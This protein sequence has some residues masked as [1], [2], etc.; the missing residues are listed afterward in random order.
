MDEQYEQANI[1]LTRA[2]IEN[3]GAVTGRLLSRVLSCDIPCAKLLIARFYANQ[4]PPRKV[5]AEFMLIGPKAEPQP[6]LDEPESDFELDS[7]T[8]TPASKPDSEPQPQP[9]ELESES[10]SSSPK[11][12]IIPFS[13]GGFPYDKRPPSPEPVTTT[14]RQL[15]SETSL[16]AAKQE[17]ACVTSQE[18]YAVAHN[19]LNASERLHLLCRANRLRPPPHLLVTEAPFPTIE[20][21]PTIIQQ[22]NSNAFKPSNHPDSDAVLNQTTPISQNPSISQNTLPDQDAHPDIKHK[23]NKKGSAGFAALINKRKSGKSTASPTPAPAPQTQSTV[24][25]ALFTA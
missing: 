3:K 19:S 10:R 5:H 14:L 15:V 16:E 24:C 23:M 2:T 9:D 21:H 6:R 12:H 20:A 11:R 18:I 17:F 25:I 4:S 8:P 7:S 22:H 13:T 1:Y